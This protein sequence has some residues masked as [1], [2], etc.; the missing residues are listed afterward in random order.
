MS[1]N[2]QKSRRYEESSRLHATHEANLLERKSAG[3]SVQLSERVMIRLRAGAFLSLCHHLRNRSDEVQNIE[4]MTIG[5]FCRNCL[6]KWLV[7]QAR[8]ISDRIGADDVAVTYFF[9]QRKRTIDSL[10]SFGYDEAAQYVYGC[11]YP[12]W[13]KLYQKKATDDQME[14]YHRSK[15]IH[16]MHDDDWLATRATRSSKEGAYAAQHIPSKAQVC[17]KEAARPSSLLSDVCCQDV[18]SLVATTTG[19]TQSIDFSHRMPSPPK[20]DLVLKI[21]ILTV[22]DR[23]FANAYETGDLSGPAV[24]STVI[25]IIKQM[26]TAFQD[27]NISISHIEKTIVPDEIPK[28][29]EVLMRWSGKTTNSDRSSKEP[30]DLVFTTGGTGF[31][32]RDVTP[33][34]TNLV[35]DRQCFG[36][37]SWA[38]M[39]LTLKQ[40]LATL[41]RASAG[42]SRDTLIINLPGNPAGA[43]QVVELLLPLLLHAVKDLRSVVDG[44][45]TS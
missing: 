27:Q 15:G 42:T 45:N 17:M 30:C 5:G 41:S 3:V 38:G 20:G 18:E 21:G 22:S 12:E 34:A 23:A 6:A 43:A 36:L 7:L 25:A 19:V 9:E 8:K 33:E 11:T 39:E 31:A 1:S 37:M 4:L 35:L 13:K 14:R 24:E 16:A 44:V 28:I 32:P 2:A 10:D 26:S 40:P 29:A